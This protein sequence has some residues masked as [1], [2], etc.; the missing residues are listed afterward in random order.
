MFSHSETI[1]VKQ[2]DGVTA[3]TA[4]SL[5]RSDSALGDSSSGTELC[6]GQ[7]TG[8]KRR[9]TRE[10]PNPET[11]GLEHNNKRRKIKPKKERLQ[12]DQLLAVSLR[13]EELSRSLQTLDTNL[14]QARAALE[15]A[16]MEVQRLMVAKQQ[17]RHRT[18]GHLLFV[19][20]G[21]NLRPS[22]DRKSQ[23]FPTKTEHEKENF[24]ELMDCKESLSGLVQ[25][26]DKEIQAGRSSPPDS[27]SH[28]KL[29]SPSRR[30]SEVGGAIESTEAPPFEPPPVPSVLHL[31]ASPGNGKRVRKLKK[32]KVLKKAQGAEQPESS[33]TELDAE[34][35]RP[36]WLRPRRRSSGGSQVSTSTLQMEDREGDMNMG[37]V[38]QVAQATPAANQ[39][40]EESM[41]VTAAT[42][43]PTEPEPVPVQVPDSSR[44]EPQNVACNE[45][46]S[47]S[48]MDISP[49]DIPTEGVFEG[50]AEAVNAIQIHNGLL[51][52]CSGDR[53]VRA[54]D[55]VSHKCV[56]VF[57]GHSSKVNCLL[58]STNPCL[59]HRLY[60]GSSDQTIRCYSLK[61]QKFQNQFSLSDRVL[62]LHS[63][64]KI[65]YAGLGNGTVVTFNLKINRQVDVFECHGPRAVSCLATS[66][67]GTRRILLVGSYDSTISVRDAKNGLLLR[68]L[69]GHSKTVL[70]MKVVN[71]LVFSGSSDQSVYAHNMHSGELMRVYQGHTHAVSVVA[72]LGKVMVTACL[73][74]LVRVYD[75]QS[76]ELLQVYGGHKDM[77]MCMNIHKNMIYTGCY[78]GSVH[79]VKLNLMQNYRCRWHGCSLVFGVLEH[80]QDHLLN[81]HATINVQTLRCR[82]KNCEEFFCTRNSSKQVEFQF[83]LLQKKK[84]IV[85]VQCVE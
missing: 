78:N 79:A 12:I 67:E 71:D 77:V 18:V 37:Q 58:L 41:E 61:Q 68:T 34:A 38:P 44:P 3:G 14:I 59:H 48:D 28:I 31:P 76:H 81:D 19:Y 75:L 63:R 24:G 7:G 83:L 17:V 4:R 11:S 60:T 22:T 42:Q 57:E 5:Q 65:L 52:T 25:M 84:N 55:L 23:L 20:L 30:G 66:Q 80:L 50:H 21:L 27:K 46:S 39:K 40:P 13:E 6:D 10:V 64:W 2:E 8:K 36:R 72:V 15:A 1:G 56:G 33:D 16:L 70:C 82:W 54:F 26:M 9:A 74:K 69:E 35:L 51:Y 32:R 43:Q 45:V 29:L 73:D 85:K 47:T 49:D 53:T 62:C